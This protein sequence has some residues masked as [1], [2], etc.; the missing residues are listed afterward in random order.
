MADAFLCV[1]ACF[2]PAALVP[3]ADEKASPVQG[4]GDRLRWKGCDLPFFDHL[5]SGTALAGYNPPPPTAEPPLHK[6]AFGKTC[7]F[8]PLNCPR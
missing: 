5:S 2:A 3:S 1:R 7:L 4:E 8:S 6:G